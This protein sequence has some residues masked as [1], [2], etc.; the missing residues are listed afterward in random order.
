[1]NERDGVKRAAQSI[2]GRL[3]GMDVGGPQRQV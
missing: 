1:M 2:G 3:V